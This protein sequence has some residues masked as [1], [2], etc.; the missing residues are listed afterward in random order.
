MEKYSNVRFRETGPAGL[1]HE[2]NA[3]KSRGGIE[4]KYYA[5]DSGLGKVI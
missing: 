5:Q 3:D 4:N 2:L 1:G